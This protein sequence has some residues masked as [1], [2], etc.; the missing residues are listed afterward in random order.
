MNKE[1]LTLSSH[2]YSISLINFQTQYKLS[3]IFVFPFE[4]FLATLYIYKY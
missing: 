2:A 4:I 1:T 3:S